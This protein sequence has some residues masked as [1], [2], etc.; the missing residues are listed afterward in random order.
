MEDQYNQVSYQKIIMHKIILQNNVEP[1]HS[2]ESLHTLQRTYHTN[3]GL[4][5]GARDISP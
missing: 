3:D 4:F 2:M 1:C 5:Q